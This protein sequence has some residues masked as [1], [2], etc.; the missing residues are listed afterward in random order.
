MAATKHEFNVEMTCEGCSGAIQRIL[1]K[2]KGN[3]VSDYQIDLPNKK[4]YIDS[5]L[6]SDQLLATLQKSKKDVK[7]VGVKG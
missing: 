7:Y 2:Q 1:E 3:G 4:V 6:P 5:T